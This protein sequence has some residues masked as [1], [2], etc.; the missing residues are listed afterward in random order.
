MDPTIL[1]VI[2]PGFLSQVPTLS[3]T[4]DSNHS[5]AELLGFLGPKRPLSDDHGSIIQ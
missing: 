1:G 2:G 4:A 5:L 3:E